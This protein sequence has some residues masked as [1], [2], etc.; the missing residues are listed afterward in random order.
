MSFSKINELLFAYGL[1]KA[2][3]II[4]AVESISVII[5][6]KIKF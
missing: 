5:I 6:L 1:K 4:Y 3:K 2:K